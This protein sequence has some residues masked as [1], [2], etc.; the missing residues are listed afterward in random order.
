VS[1]CTHS[2]DRIR[3]AFSPLDP[4]NYRASEVPTESSIYS[5]PSHDLTYYNNPTAAPTTKY[6][7]ISPPSSPGPEQHQTSTSSQPRRFKSMRDVSPMDE[8][9]GKSANAPHG[10]GIPVLR[11]AP[12]TIQTGVAPPTQKFWGGKVAP[13]SKVRWDEY[14]GEPTASNAGRTG[15]VSPGSYA[16]DV[17]TRQPMTMGY[18]VSISG[19][20]KKSVGFSERLGRTSARPPPVETTKHEPWSRATGRSQIAPPLKDQPSDRPLQL[21]RKTL[22]PTSERSNVSVPNALAASARRGVE[23]ADTGSVAD[24]PHDLNAHDDL[25]KPTVPLKVGRNTPPRIFASPVTPTY[26]KGLGIQTYPSPRTPTHKTSTESADTVIHEQAFAKEIPA[27]QRITTPPQDPI[28]RKSIDHTPPKDKQAPTSRFSWTTYNSSTTYQHSPPPSPPN[29]PTATPPRQ[30]VVTEPISAATAASSILSRRRPVPQADTTSVSVP[31][32]KAAAPDTPG[33]ALI[34]PAMSSPTSPGPVSPSSASVY[35][36]AT[37]GTSKALPLPPTSLSAADHIAVLES[38]MEDLRIRRSNVYRLLNDL[39]NAAPPNPL[40]TDFKRARLVEQ[41][42][43]A[44]EDELSEIKREE[45]DVGM[46]LHRAW[47]KRER[48]DPNQAGSAIWVR[49]VTS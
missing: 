43:R 47:K 33:T 2:A 21:P 15:S 22:S 10:S 46:K 35:S 49:R 17:A 42:K 44:F 6:G 8:N 29:L 16:K 48:D 28:A 12:P 23:G 24:N 4:P 39:N 38:A 9:R 26:P 19:P 30:R 32:P 25:I 14:S 1:C 34:H 36:T 41:R 31:T 5:R 7:E 18:Q 27:P 13:D 11:K 20:S 37:T 3:S 40:I 45:Y